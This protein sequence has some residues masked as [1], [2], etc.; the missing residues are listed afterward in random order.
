M[1]YYKT[2]MFPVDDLLEKKLRLFTEVYFPRQIKGANHSTVSYI[3]FMPETDL[4]DY[5]QTIKR[6]IVSGG[7]SYDEKRE[8]LMDVYKSLTEQFTAGIESQKNYTR[9][10]LIKQMQGV[11]MMGLE[12]ED[13]LDHTIPDIL[14]SK[15]VSNKK[16][17]QIISRFAEVNTYLE[18]ILRLGDAYDFCYST[19]EINR[20][21]WIPAADAF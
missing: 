12:L 14:D 10:D 21:Y 1:V 3:L 11:Q 8:S 9:S 17:D 19:D 7:G 20:Y 6:C 18:G 4:R 2:G 5:Q 16:V 15:K 13:P